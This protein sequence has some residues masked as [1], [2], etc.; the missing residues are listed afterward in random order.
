[1]GL[2]LSY[3]QLAD[4][5]RHISDMQNNASVSASSGTKRFYHRDVI[6]LIQHTY[7]R[8]LSHHAESIPE[9]VRYIRSNNKITVT[10]TE[11]LD[12]FKEDK[13]L[14]DILFH[15]SGK[16]GE[17]IDQLIRIID[18]LGQRLS[19]L[20]ANGNTEI[21][22]DLEVLY[23][24]RKVVTNL[25]QQLSVFEPVWDIKAIQKLIDNELR[26]TRL[27]FE[28]DK[29]E[30]LQVMGIMET[31]CLDFKNVV[32]LSM[33]EG[34]FPSGKSLSTFF[35]YDLRRG[36]TM[37]T[38]R[39]RDSVAAYLFYRLM[40][41]SENV[42][43]VYNTESD[44]LGGGEKSRFILQ[45][46]HEFKRFPKIRM[47]ERNFVLGAEVA[48]V[49]HPILIEKNEGVQTLLKTYLSEKGLSPTALN[50]YIN[51]SLQFYFKNILGLREQDDIEESL[52]ASTIGTAVHYALEHIYRDVLNKPLQISYLK[53]VL[54]NTDGIGKLIKEYLSE[55]FEDESLK[56]GKNYLLYNV[57]KSLVINFLK[58]EIKRVEA[59]SEDGKT[60]TV[61][62][63]EQKLEQRLKLGGYD[64]Y[65]HG[66]TDRVEQ[67][68]GVTGIADYKTGDSK[69]GKV[70]I[71]D[72]ALLRSSPEYSKAFQLMMYAWLY[73]GQYGRQPAGIRSGIY[74]LRHADGKYESLLKDKSDLIGDSTLDSFQA[75]LEEILTEMLSP[76]A[77]FTKTEDKDRCKFCD[78]VRICGRD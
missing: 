12:W 15:K 8:L 48:Q 36:G 58:N 30:G 14:I 59:L 20:R 9:A 62:L 67:V 2:P 6:A 28:S 35:P 69:K 73:R 50:T 38:H 27:P 16:A 54:S 18:L 11:L 78:F 3:M 65:I 72:M 4:F 57:C 68:G 22:T 26:N 37:T 75:I 13:E 24:L 64:I 71:D 42:Y 70:K 44:L 77:H 5:M 74:W 1:M 53:G 63:L 60:V 23:W 21:D 17:Y 40:Q 32:I 76:Q 41:R 34:I 47:R 52:E 39:E 61:T 43:L 55:R 10:K 49:E 51:C 56:Q 66:N 45:I 31:R 29:A 46:Q 19:A 7:F 25:Q 33:N